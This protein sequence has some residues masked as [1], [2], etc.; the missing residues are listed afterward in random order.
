VTAATSAL[1][2]CTVLAFGAGAASAWGENGRDAK[3]RGLKPEADTYVSADEPDRN[4]GGH[5]VLRAARSPQTT[6]YLRFRHES[7]GRA[8]VS[9]TLLVHVRAGDRARFQVRRVPRDQWREDRLTHATA[10]RPSLR[11]ASSSPVRGG[12]WSAVDVTP[13]LAAGDDTITLAITTRSRRGIVF[14]SRES[15]RRPML[16]VRTGGKV[17][18]AGQD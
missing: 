4:F 5:R 6:A 17:D 18:R 9:V 3:I 7:L 15:K 8:L 16:V 13:F 2:A 12:R 10:P 14:D 1:C 11:Y